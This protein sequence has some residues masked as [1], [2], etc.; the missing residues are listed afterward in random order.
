[1]NLFIKCWS[2]AEPGFVS[3]LIDQSQLTKNYAIEVSEIVNQIINE[4][5][6]NCL[7]DEK[8]RNCIYLNIITNYDDKISV[9]YEGLIRKVAD[10]YLRIEKNTKKIN[11]GTGKIISIKSEDAIWIEP[12]YKGNLS[13]IKGYNLAYDLTRKWL[14]KFPERPIPI[15]INISKESSLDFF[16]TELYNGMFAIEELENNIGDKPLII[17][18]QSKNDID[19]VKFILGLTHPEVQAYNN[20]LFLKKMGEWK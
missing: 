2:V 3:I 6:I 8:V 10:N 18:I 7:G 1:M 15:I 4:L 5:I 19:R 20:E 17:N 9:L 14:K 11:D 16:S 13:V 12:N